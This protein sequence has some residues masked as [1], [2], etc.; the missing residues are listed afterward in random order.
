VQSQRLVVASTSL[1]A[2]PF[3]ALPAIPASSRIQS[4]ALATDPAEQALLILNA[5]SLS[6]VMADPQSSLEFAAIDGVF[7]DLGSA[8]AKTLNFE[9]NSAIEA[10]LTVPTMRQPV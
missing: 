10:E 2:G 9:L 5:A 6:A 4:S 3:I 8:T 7:T 1:S